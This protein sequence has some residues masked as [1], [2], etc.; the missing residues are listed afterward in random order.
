VA[1]LE[2][3]LRWEE[4]NITLWPGDPLDR[5]NKL[6]HS[7]SASGRGGFNAQPLDMSSQAGSSREDLI[8]DTLLRSP[9]LGSTEL[10]SSIIEVMKSTSMGK[11]RFIPERYRFSDSREY[12]EVFKKSHRFSL[13]NR[14][15]SGCF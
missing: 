9:V 11:T 10:I 12:C 14:T 7:Q 2:S 4:S 1:E 6:V 3:L 13:K 8:D 5:N 15:S